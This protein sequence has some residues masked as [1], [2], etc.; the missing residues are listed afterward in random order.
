[1]TPG[2]ALRAPQGSSV[3]GRQHPRPGTAPKA[4][5]TFND[6]S[7]RRDPPRWVL[8]TAGGG[9]RKAKDRHSHHSAAPAGQEAWPPGSRKVQ[10]GSFTLCPRMQ[11][12][13]QCARTTA[14]QG[15]SSPPRPLPAWAAGQGKSGGVLPPADHPPPWAWGDHVS[16]PQGE[17]VTGPGAAWIPP[18]VHLGAPGPLGPP[19]IRLYSMRLDTGSP[20][21]V[22]ATVNPEC[23]S[24]ECQQCPP[25][26]G[27]AGSHT[28]RTSPRPGRCVPQSPRL[29][30][31]GTEPRP[32]NRPLLCRPLPA[33]PWGLDP[34]QAGHLLAPAGPLLH[35]P[36]GRRPP[37]RHRVISSLLWG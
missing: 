14:M 16:P 1:M 2:L 36:L 11:K 26:R 7:G 29:A 15:H 5:D 28:T 21:R 35:L 12:C 13:Q 30:S 9:D 3:A 37:R 27:L 31:R 6:P 25:Y 18:R 8:I 24:P 33:G 20:W 34:P 17:E 32:Q 23:P 19:Q 10:L 22:A 4:P